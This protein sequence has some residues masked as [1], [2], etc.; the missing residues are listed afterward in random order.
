M[1][2]GYCPE[3]ICPCQIKAI[4]GFRPFCRLALHSGNYF[5]CYAEA[6][7]LGT[8]PLVN[9]CSY[10]LRYCSFNQKLICVMLWRVFPRSSKVLGLI[11]KSLKFFSWLLYGQRQASSFSILHVH[12]HFFQNHLLKKLSFHGYVLACL[13]RTAVTL[14]DFS[15]ISYLFSWSMCLYL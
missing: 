2:S 1:L 5:L 11:L 10:F 3:K 7:Y 6:F 14:L 9:S 4:E 15:S 13:Q 8:I 12:S